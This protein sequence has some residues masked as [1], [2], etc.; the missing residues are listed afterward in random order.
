MLPAVGHDCTW[1]AY[2]VGLG[3]AGV[4]AHADYGEEG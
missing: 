2:R 4:N 3:M 1:A